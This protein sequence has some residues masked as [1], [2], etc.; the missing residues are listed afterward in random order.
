VI[1]VGDPGGS[2]W[3]Q[4]ADVVAL[5]LAPEQGEATGTVRAVGDRAAEVL[6]GLRVDLAR[7][8][9][10]EP[11]T[12]RA[13]EVTRVPVLGDGPSPRLLLVGVG[14]D[15]PRDL[16]RSA[17]GLARAVRGRARLVTTLGTGS[18]PA[19]VRAV[20][21]GLVLGGYAPPAGGV[22]PRA[23]SAPVGRVELI[24]D[25]RDPAVERGR[26]HAAATALARDLAETPANLKTPS[27][28][29]DRAAEIAAERGLD[30][31][32]WR[33]ADL[34]AAGF[35]GLRAVGGGW[36]KPP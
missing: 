9:E 33:G 1:C 6:A 27:W 10:A 32:I 28:L 5:A 34:E 24:G 36:A 18:G 15:G 20:V 35:G 29:A 13:G 25:Q 22:T 2:R 8:A 19:G 12:G 31:R 3:W 30:V 4:D 26:L 23:D 11:V 16:R 21:E 14:D 7:V 17:A